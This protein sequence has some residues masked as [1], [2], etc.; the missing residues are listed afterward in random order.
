MLEDAP[1]Y[2]KQL[3]RFLLKYLNIKRK[4]GTKGFPFLSSEQLF[5][6]GLF[7][8]FVGARFIS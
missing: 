5:T 3:W 1:E 4:G 2:T 7:T 8:E 6:V